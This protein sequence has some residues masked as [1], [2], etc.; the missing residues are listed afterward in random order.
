MQT[1]N[2]AL[3]MIEDGH[4]AHD[5]TQVQG[6]ILEAIQQANRKGSR[7]AK[8]TLTLKLSY[9][10]KDG[11]VEIA[12]D[13]KSALPKVQAAPAKRPCSALW[14]TE[15]NGLSCKDPI[16]TNIIEYINDLSASS[17]AVVS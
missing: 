13:I 2:E 10:L 1:F 11:V 5:L 8:G 3:S 12:S 16:Q 7:R 6:E 17:D 15:D 4:L 9:S 14:L